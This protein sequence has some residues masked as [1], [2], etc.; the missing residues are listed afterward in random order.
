MS[1]HVSSSMSQTP[2]EPAAPRPMTISG[3]S[4]QR[5][6]HIMDYVKVLYRR[7]WAAGTAFMVVLLAAIVYTFTAT[8]VYESRVQLLIEAENPN[9]VSFKEVIDQEKTTNDY[10]Q[11]QY[12]I[13]QSRS[14]A[15]KT[16]DAGKLWPKLFEI[17]ITQ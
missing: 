9:V 14:L 3:G 13:L 17:K 15:R 7:R 16:L 6:A 4:F 11:T 5:D 1:D 2:A 10:Y 8:P 12:R